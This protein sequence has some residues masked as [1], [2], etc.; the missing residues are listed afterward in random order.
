MPVELCSE[1]GR[2]LLMKMLMIINGAAYGQDTTYNALRLAKTLAQRDNVSLRIFL[3]GD[4]VT[5]RS[6]GRQE[7]P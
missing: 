2:N 6:H 1:E 7:D 3:M 5:V 4:G